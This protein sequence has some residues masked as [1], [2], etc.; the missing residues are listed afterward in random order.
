MSF[1]FTFTFGFDLRSAINGDPHQP[2]FQYDASCWTRFRGSIEQ[3]HQRAPMCD[4]TLWQYST[5]FFSRLDTTRYAPV[6]RNRARDC[7]IMSVNSSSSGNDTRIRARIVNTIRAALREFGVMRI[8][9][10][11]LSESGEKIEATIPDVVGVGLK[12]AAM[13]RKVEEETRRAGEKRARLEQSWAAREDEEQRVR[14][15]RD[16]MGLEL[17]AGAYVE[18][19]HSNDSRSP[20]GYANEEGC[21]GEKSVGRAD[22]A[23]NQARA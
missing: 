3:A 22:M 14:A 20:L 10:W 17:V 7:C 9:L 12:F 11:Y 23:E 15:E 21:D 1:T 18:D 2:N 16:K 8:D 4:Y 5:V 6:V 19:R 13:T